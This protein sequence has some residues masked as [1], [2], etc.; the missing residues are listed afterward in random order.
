MQFT[1]RE[2]FSNLRQFSPLHNPAE[3]FRIQFMQ[4]HIINHFP[5]SSQDIWSRNVEK[6]GVATI[7]QSY[8]MKTTL[9]PSC[10][11]N[12]TGAAPP[13]CVFSKNL[14]CIFDLGLGCLC[15]VAFS[16]APLVS[17]LYQSSPH[18]QWLQLQLQSKPIGLHNI[19]IPLTRAAVFVVSQPKVVL[20][21]WELLRKQLCYSRSYLCSCVSVPFLYLYNISAELGV[22]MLMSCV[23]MSILYIL[24]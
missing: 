6:E 12:S 15:H 19:H 20:Y 24:L 5:L 23:Y 10:S 14:E 13:P 17:F 1:H 3:F 7:Y 9:C 4:Q 22:N 2:S 18:P 16:W 8:E 21:S 11:L